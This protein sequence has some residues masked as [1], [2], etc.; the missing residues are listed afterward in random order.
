M[1]IEEQIHAVEKL[2]L[3]NYRAFSLAVKVM[4]WAAN[5]KLDFLRPKNFLHNENISHFK[6]F[7]PRTDT[8]K[9]CILVS[10]KY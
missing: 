7:I 10:R 4:K 6:F 2:W 8:K 5:S 3:G 9:R 1:A